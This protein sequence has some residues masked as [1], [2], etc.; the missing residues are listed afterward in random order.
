MKT[1]GAQPPHPAAE[2][3]NPSGQDDLHAQSLTSG[4]WATHPVTEQPTLTLTQW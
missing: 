3:A 1:T 4:I 2:I